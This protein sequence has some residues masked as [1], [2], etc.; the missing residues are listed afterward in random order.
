MRRIKAAIAGILLVGSAEAEPSNPAMLTFTACQKAIFDAAQP[1][2]PL[3]FEILMTGPTRRLWTGETVATLFVRIDY[4]GRGGRE[5]RRSH[6]E[7]T[8]HLKGAVTITPLRP[9]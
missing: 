7:C 6:V 3:A 9:E 1:Y 4:N 8:L 2:D 5:T